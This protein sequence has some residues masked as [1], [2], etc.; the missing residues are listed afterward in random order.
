M[1]YFA[2]RPSPKATPPS[3]AQRPG[4]P[5][6]SDSQASSATAQHDSSGTSVVIRKAENETPGRVA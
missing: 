1:A 3:T 6:I 5:R 4:P 2:S